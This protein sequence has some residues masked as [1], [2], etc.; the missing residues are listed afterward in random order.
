M[1]I[2]SSQDPNSAEETTSGSTPYPVTPS[3]LSSNIDIGMDGIVEKSGNEND[4][5]ILN[6]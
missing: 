3:L 5:E 2:T 4:K 1:R 6:S